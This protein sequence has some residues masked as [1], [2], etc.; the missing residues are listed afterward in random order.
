M[1]TTNADIQ[2]TDVTNG[3]R[4]ILDRSPGNFI[5][6]LLTLT[7]PLC[8]PRVYVPDTDTYMYALPHDQSTISYST[9]V[10]CDSS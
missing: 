2:N 10:S 6:P 4:T 7:T 8:Q 1:I 9:L 5:H 3:I